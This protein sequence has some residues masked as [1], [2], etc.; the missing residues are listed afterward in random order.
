MKEDNLDS[1]V[2]QLKTE[3]GRQAAIIRAVNLG[4]TIKQEHLIAARNFR[5]SNEARQTMQQD[6][7]DIYLDKARKLRPRKRGISYLESRGLYNIAGFYASQ[8]NHHELAALN[9]ERA[10]NFP[11][12]ERQSA[13]AGNKEQAK[14]YRSLADM[15]G[16]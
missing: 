1:L 5:Y 14:I 13:L 9:Y 2:S 8:S 12:A 3:I 15:L 7:T 4:K 11:E 10:G 16:M 6:S